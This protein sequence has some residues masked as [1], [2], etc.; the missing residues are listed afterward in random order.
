MKKVFNSIV[1][2]L[3]LKLHLTMFD[4]FDTLS[5]LLAQVSLSTLSPT[6]ACLGAVGGHF[7]STTRIKFVPL[8]TLYTPQQVNYRGIRSVCLHTDRYLPA[9]RHGRSTISDSFLNLP[10]LDNRPKTRL[11][12]Q[13]E[14]LRKARVFKRSSGVLPH[15]MEQL[16]YMSGHSARV[17]DKLGFSSNELEEMKRVKFAENPTLFYGRG[18]VQPPATSRAHQS[19]SVQRFEVRLKTALEHSRN[20]GLG[21]DDG[22]DSGCETTPAPTIEEEEEH[23]EEKHHR[24]RTFVTETRTG[25]DT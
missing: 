12:G 5:S 25:C 19:R 2:K 16:F 23:R 3:V 24:R 21:D 7:N 22:L 17:Q 11:V 15:R 8:P 9:E 1:L 6:G 14:R 10:L 4:T 20:Y 18:L 13:G